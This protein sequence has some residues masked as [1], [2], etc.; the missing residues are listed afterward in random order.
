MHESGFMPASTEPGAKR[1][2]VKN[3]REGSTP[4]PFG[5]GRNS[6]SLILRRTNYRPG[7]VAVRDEP[8][9]GNTVELP[10]KFTL[11]VLQV[12]GKGLR[13]DGVCEKHEPQDPP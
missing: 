11:L 9:G 6:R 2:A 12:E 1:R 3:Y 7:K 8:I 10:V 4:H 13:V 5:G